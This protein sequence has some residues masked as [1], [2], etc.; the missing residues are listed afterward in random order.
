MIIDSKAKKVKIR[1][2]N[3]S[4]KEVRKDIALNDL[5]YRF[6]PDLK[7]CQDDNFDAVLE[8]A[9]SREKSVKVEFPNLK[10]SGR[11]SVDFK[12][13]DIIVLAEY[14]LERLRQESGFSVLHSSAVCKGD[15]GVLLFG[16]LTGIGK[17]S[18]AIQ[19]AQNYK[20]DIY[21]DEKTILDLTKYK[22]AGQTKK[23]ILEAKTKNNFAE[24]VKEEI[25]I[26]EQS[27]K[28]IS[29]FI[30]PLL[31]PDMKKSMTIKYSKPQFKW[32]LYEEIS[33]DIRSINGLIFNYT[34]PLMSL[35][36]PQLAKQRERFVD[37]IV[38]KT[39]CYLI[40][41]SLEEVANKVVQLV[42]NKS[43]SS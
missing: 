35:D 16:N 20:F 34:Y 22:L 41:G 36:T 13:T 2:I 14:L 3:F 42:E 38:N 26:E 17:T 27:N 24:T 12:S 43:S 18:L 6:V 9:Q 40:K 32:M 4:G 1:F 37:Y 25:K 10:I 31:S 21:S 19:L 33:K 8:I 28:N 7:I 39:K 23:I 5:L 11:Y 30:I 29:I 15:E